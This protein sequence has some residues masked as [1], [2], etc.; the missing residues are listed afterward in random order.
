MSFCS[1]PWLSSPHRASM[2]SGIHLRINEGVFTAHVLRSY[3]GLKVVATTIC[4][5]ASARGEAVGQACA[6]QDESASNGGFIRS[7]QHIARDMGNWGFL[8]NRQR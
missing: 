2:E 3:S 4:S 8:W 1:R 7:M 6:G 5:A